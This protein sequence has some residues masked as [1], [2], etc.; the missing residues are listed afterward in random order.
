[1]QTTLTRASGNDNALRTTHDLGQTVKKVQP[2]SIGTFYEVTI[3]DNTRLLY[4]EIPREGPT[5]LLKFKCAGS[6]HYQFLMWSCRAGRHHFFRGLVALYRYLRKNKVTGHSLR[7]LASADNS[8]KNGGFAIRTDGIRRHQEM[9]S[10]LKAEKRF[11]EYVAANLPRFLVAHPPLDGWQSAA[12]NGNQS[13]VLFKVVDER[14]AYHVV[15]KTESFGARIVCLSGKPKKFTLDSFQSFDHM[16]DGWPRIEADL[17]VRRQ[18][19]SEAYLV[20]IQREM[21]VLA[22]RIVSTSEQGVTVP[23]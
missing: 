2:H 1:M 13:I 14:T 3:D 8:N 7:Y 4:R 21:A 12:T 9:L 17:I 10:R 5:I 18:A 16:L 22:A 6:W 20:A 19:D 23:A 15:I 11:D